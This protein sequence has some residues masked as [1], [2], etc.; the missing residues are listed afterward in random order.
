MIAIVDGLAI[1][2]GLDPD[3]ADVGAATE[4]WE[5]L[6]RPFLTARDERVRLG[7]RS[8][9]GVC[10]R[11][12]G[13]L[14]PMKPAIIWDEAYAQHDTGEHP[15][16]AD[17]VASLVGHLEGTDL[18]E[19][20]TVVT[21]P[22]PA[23]EDD[24]LLVH[25]P[26]HLAM[27]KRAAQ[28]KGT[29]LD[30]DTHVSP[31]SYEIA[32]LSAGG[33]LLATESVEGRPRAVR[34]HP[35]ARP[36]CD[37]GQ[38]DGLLPLQQHRH[39]RRQAARG[40]LRARR[41]PRLGRAPRQRHAGGVLRR[42]QGPLRLG[43]RVAAL[44]GQRLLHGVRRG[45]GGGLHRQRPAPG[46]GAATAT[47][48][49]SSTS[50]ST[51]SC[52]SSSRRRS[53]S[54][55]ART[56]TATTRSATCASTRPASRRWRCAACGSRRTCARAGWRSCWRAATT[57]ARRREPSRRCCARCADETAPEGG[58][59]TEKAAAAIGAG[60]RGPVGVLG[61]LRARRPAPA[62]PPVRRRSA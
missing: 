46:R 1:Q 17:R 11:R 62:G 7:R 23:T 33:A 48:R 50:S 32:L 54:R 36:P 53:W 4:L 24:V 31:R 26:A 30:P 10:P 47:T 6:A 16:G 41:H 5:R 3:G 20:L 38:G 9:D 19:R 43:A 40:G 29:W 37:A 57:A 56:S 28:G 12:S 13:I 61:R 60:A 2:H 8:A 34:G 45:G 21:S 27:I 59:G 35:P 58:G 49:A 14:G 22:A 25:T 52:G 15:E 55:P 18:W 42:A 51:R 44:S 39:R